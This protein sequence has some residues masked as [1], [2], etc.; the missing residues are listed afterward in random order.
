[1]KTELKFLFMLCVLIGLFAGCSDEVTRPQIE[2]APD[3]FTVDATAT[4]M[5]ARVGDWVVFHADKRDGVLPYQGDYWYFRDQNVWVGEECYRQMDAEGFFTMVV[6]SYDALGTIACDS[7]TVTVLPAE[8]QPLSINL[9]AIPA[10]LEVNN[11]TYLQTHVVGGAQPYRSYTFYKDGI[12]M[13]D[14]QV[15][16][17]RM[18]MSEQ[19]NFNFRVTV[20]DSLG[21]SAS[22]SITV[23]VVAPNIIE[24][25]VDS[26]LKVGPADRDDYDEVHFGQTG[27][28]NVTVAMRFDT[29]ERRFVVLSF[30]YADGSVSYFTIPDLGVARPSCVLV[31]LGQVRV[32]PTM[33]ISMRWTGSPS[34]C[35]QW[36]RATQFCVSLEGPN[37]SADGIPIIRLGA[38]GNYTLIE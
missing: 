2:P 7:V 9:E 20:V 33:T 22:D 24:T 27:V 13:A 37:K 31:D 12:Q 30:H 34:K 28:G 11:Y 23:S 10:I 21:T 6:N 3:L 29:S 8:V 19:G 26:D 35:D 4:P 14:N 32:E 15:G 38:D 5:V 17:L 18:L 16:W 1:M 36:V 25:C